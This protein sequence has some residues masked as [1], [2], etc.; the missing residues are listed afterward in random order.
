MYTLWQDLRYALRMQGK[1][2]GFTATVIL[3]LALGIATTTAIFSVVYGVLL[4]PLPYR[5]PEEIVR[6]WEQ[7]DTGGQMNFA[8]PNFEDVRVQNQS[9][10]GVAEYASNLA[11]VVVGDEAS[12][13]TAYVSRDFL[14][15]MGVEPIF[16]RPFAGDEQK[17][18]AAPV[19]LISHSYWQHS[20]AAT[21]DHSALRFESQLFEVSPTDPTT[22]PFLTSLLFLVSLLACWIPARRATRV[23]P[24]EALRYE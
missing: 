19:A 15:I 20:F 14:Q 13:Q 5:H 1:T 16:G 3:A 21:R 11:T 2:P 4:R 7:N 24:M 22:F 17:P 18:G 12:R 8:D 23:D 10:A 9:L 6:L